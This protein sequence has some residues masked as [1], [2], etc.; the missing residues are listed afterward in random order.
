MIFAGF[1]AIAK[2][3]FMKE[4]PKNKTARRDLVFIL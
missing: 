1:A 4:T 3:A 2:F